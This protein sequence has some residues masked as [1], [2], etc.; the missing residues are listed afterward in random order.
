MRADFVQKLFHSLAIF[1]VYFILKLLSRIWWISWCLCWASSSFVRWGS[2]YIASRNSV[3]H[4]QL[5]GSIICHPA[6]IWYGV[7]WGPYNGFRYHCR[8]KWKDLVR[9][10]RRGFCD[11]RFSR[12][13]TLVEHND[14]SWNICCIFLW[15][16]LYV[17]INVSKYI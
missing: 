6:T 11:Q 14:L 16:C 7:W 8:Q 9:S 10:N 13:P 12:E 2:W 5:Q 17:L 4:C 3:W 1:D 15:F